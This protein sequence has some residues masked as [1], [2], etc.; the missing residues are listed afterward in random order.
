ML[1][2]GVIGRFLI[3]ICDRRVVRELMTSREW[4][5]MHGKGR[6]MQGRAGPSLYDGPSV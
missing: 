6:S 3:Y 1:R 2:E 4:V 5:A